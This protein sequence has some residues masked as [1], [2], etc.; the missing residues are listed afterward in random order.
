[1]DAPYRVVDSLEPLASVTFIGRDAIAP[2]W[3]LWAVLAS[4]GVYL[5]ELPALPLGE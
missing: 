1:M 4:A 3:L 5:W 2:W